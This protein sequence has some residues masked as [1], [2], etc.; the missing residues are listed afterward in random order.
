MGLKKY[1]YYVY[2]LFLDGRLTN[3]TLKIMFII[4]SIRWRVNE[5]SNT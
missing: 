5:G 2:Y 1:A 4:E 3:H